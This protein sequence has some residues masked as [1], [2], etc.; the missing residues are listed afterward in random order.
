MARII[1]HS[2]LCQAVQGLPFVFET[3]LKS[4]D[5]V[6]K[7][8]HNLISHLP[9]T[10]NISC[11]EG[12]VRWV[13]WH[14]PGMLYTVH[15]AVHWTTL[16]SIIPNVVITDLNVTN[17]FFQPVTVICHISCLQKSSLT[18]KSKSLLLI[19]Y[20]INLFISF[21]ELIAIKTILPGFPGG[22]VVKNLPASAEDLG[23]IPGPGDPTCHR[24]TKPVCH[25]YWA[26]ALE[27]MGWKY[28]SSCAYS[29]CSIKSEAPAMR[30][31]MNCS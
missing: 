3:E 25:D 1:R 29:Q 16:R 4:F 26:Q 21:I 31:P 12:F 20:L 8:S 17:N 15:G 7:D 27:P 30:S 14:L 19:L 6:C 22:L 11:F 24:A 5:M 23:S 28:W 13:R 2:L 10:G 9:G 18:T